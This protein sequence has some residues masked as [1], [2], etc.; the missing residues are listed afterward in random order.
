MSKRSEPVADLTRRILNC[1]PSR[2]TEDDWTFGAAML[3]GVAHV[4]LPPEKNLH[5]EWWDIGDQ[6]RSGSCVGWAAADAVLRWHFVQAGWIRPENHLSVRFT[7]MASKETDEFTSAATTFIEPEGTSLKAA[8][9]IARRYGSVLDEDLPFAGGQ[10]F[11]DTAQVFYAKAARLKI[12]SYINLELSLTSWRR[13][14]ASNGPILVRLDVDQTWD[15][16]GADG[17]LATYRPET[18][19]GGHAVALVGYDRNGFIVRNSWGA[20]WAKGGLAYATDAY[21]AAAFTEA[22]GVTLPT[23][24]VA[25]GVSQ[26]AIAYTQK[27]ATAGAAFAAAA[28][29]A[30]A[31]AVEEIEAVVIGAA[32]RVA[33]RNDFGLSNTVGGV[34]Q[35]LQAVNA[36]LGEVQRALGVGMVLASAPTAEKM[37]LTK[38]SFFALAD[39]VRRRLAAANAEDGQ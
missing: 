34:F 11:P 7:W 30:V 37:N 35:S 6:G 38:G 27:V 17:V 14:I 21:A 16:V 18:A 12:A 28:A 36:L 29:Q 32:H 22:Y 2:N 4:D 1:L 31:G 33:R 25:P 8:L 20:G 3:A 15:E 5:E 19:S 13:W 24:V 39:W 10:L 9:D 23:T 26:E